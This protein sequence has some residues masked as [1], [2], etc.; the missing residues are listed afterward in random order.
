MSA[1]SARPDAVFIDLDSTILNEGYV[2]IAS[3]AACAELALAHPDIDAPALAHANLEVWLS[4][5]PEIEHDWTLGELETDALRDEVWRRTLARFGIEDE[6]MVAEVSA[7]H[8]AHEL[9][10]YRAF[11]DVVPFLDALRAAGI[12]V[13]VLT[14][15]ASDLQRVK[16][17]VLG[18]TDRVDALIV[19]GEHGAA[20]PDPAIFAHALDA[21]GADASRAAHIGDSLRADVGGA[22]ASGVTAIW[23]NR[24][25]ADRPAGASEPDIEVQ[26]LSELASL[27]GIAS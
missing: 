12:R 26:S 5:W 27:W 7:I 8:Q 13:A 2:P 1:E 25:L 11:D 16:L 18:I 3:A 22:L 15:G 24:D 19:S 23:L 14:N 17:D 9:D 4:Y 21:V 20:K 6:A 10:S